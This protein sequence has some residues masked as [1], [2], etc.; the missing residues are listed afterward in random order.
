M[1]FPFTVSSLTMLF[2]AGALVAIGCGNAGSGGIPTSHSGQDSYSSNTGTNGNTTLPGTLSPIDNAGAIGTGPDSSPLIGSP[3]Q[4][5]SDSGTTTPVNTQ[6]GGGSSAQGGSDGGSGKG[7]GQGGSS[8]GADCN[9]ICACPTIPQASK[10][11]CQAICKKPSQACLDCATEAGSDCNKLT[12]CAQACFS[13]GGGGSSQGGGGSA[14][15]GGGDPQGGGGSAQGGG[16]DPQGGG[17]SP[18]GGGGASSGATC[19]DLSACCETLNPQ[20]KMAY[21]AT[22]DMYV[23][24]GNDASCNAVYSSLKMLCAPQ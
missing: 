7:Q 19:S 21:Q 2:S 5:T 3:N 20:Y 18:Q 9:A 15:G 6:G 16:G 8:S 10:A 4:G 17:G 12:A 11:A 23:Q 13:G 22:C 1:K 24:M 14:Q